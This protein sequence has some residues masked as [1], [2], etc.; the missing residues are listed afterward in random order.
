M[1][2]YA[3]STLL[4]SNSELKRP[5]SAGFSQKHSSQGGASGSHWGSTPQAVIAWA[6]KT[7]WKADE[8]RPKRRN[9]PESAPATRNRLVSV[10]DNPKLN[11]S[12]PNIDWLSSF[13]D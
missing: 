5:K 7:D 8:G 6:D 2:P 10:I 3:V 1:S 9:R 12:F 13:C 4:D 11:V